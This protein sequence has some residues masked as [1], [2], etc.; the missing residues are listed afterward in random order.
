M[1]STVLVSFFCTYRAASDE[2]LNQYAG[3]WESESGQWLNRITSEVW[4]EAMSAAGRE[5]GKRIAEIN[6][7]K[8]MTRL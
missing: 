4:F 5:A 3:Y 7:K 6:P 2:E 8:S 1:K